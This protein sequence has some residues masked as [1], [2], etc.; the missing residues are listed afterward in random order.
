MR[1]RTV[2]AFIAAVVCAA[3]IAIANRAWA[4]KESCGNNCSVQGDCKG[5][6]CPVCFSWPGHPRCAAT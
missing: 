1:K 6:T 3:N 5:G 4:A 2:V